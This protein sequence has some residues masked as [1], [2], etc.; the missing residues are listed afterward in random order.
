MPKVNCDNKLCENYSKD[1]RAACIAEEIQISNAGECL[2]ATDFTT[3][4]EENFEEGG[5][6]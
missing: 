1:K 2:N 4:E 3:I 6:R 5:N